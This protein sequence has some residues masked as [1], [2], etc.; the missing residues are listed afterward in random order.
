ME[1]NNFSDFKKNI[2]NIKSLILVYGQEKTIINKTIELVYDLITQF[3]EI[4][5]L[6]MDGENVSIESIINACETTPFMSEKRLIHIK[7]ANYIF[8]NNALSN[9][10]SKYLN[11]IPDTNILLLSSYSNVD[12]SGNLYKLFRTNGMVIEYKKLK[13]ENLQEYIQNYL[14]KENKT[15]TKS[16][17]LYLTS[18]LTLCNE[19]IDL[20]LKKLVDYLGDKKTVDKID[21]DLILSKSIENNIFR[22]LDYITIKELDDAVMVYN[23]MILQGEEELMI[24]SMIFRNY[25]IMYLLKIYGENYNDVVKKYNIRDFALKNYFKWIKKYELSDLKKNIKRC[26]EYDLKIKQGEL[27]ASIAVENLIIELCA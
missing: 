16:N 15:I 8:E 24:L 4:N 26:Y 18:E 7:N 20:E 23:Q 11:N 12:K 5:V 17:L 22:L 21:I 25:K 9:E 14:N 3:K 10:L 13:G 6:I 2:K 27:N 1:L 19:N